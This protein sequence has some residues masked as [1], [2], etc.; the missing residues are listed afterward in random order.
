MVRAREQQGFGMVN[1]P[2]STDSRAKLIGAKV[3]GHFLHQ[4]LQALDD[5]RM[6][7]RDIRVLANVLREVEQ[8]G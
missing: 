6:L 7:R 3:R 1:P 8:L 4:Q 2:G 5:F